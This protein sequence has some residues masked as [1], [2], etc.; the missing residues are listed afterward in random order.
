MFL[1]VKLKSMTSVRTALKAGHYIVS[2]CEHVH[3]LTLTFIAPL[4]AEKHI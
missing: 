1:A 4:K 3:H 2:R